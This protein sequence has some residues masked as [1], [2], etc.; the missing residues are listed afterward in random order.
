MKELL[1]KIMEKSLEINQKEKN[2]I[3]IRWYG[4]LNQ[5]E[6]DMYK[7]GWAY[8]K[9]ADVNYEVDLDEPN[10]KEKLE[11]ILKILED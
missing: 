4:F 3:N 8:H 5:F 6:F 9:K 1:L 11:E 7:D 10:A 2:T